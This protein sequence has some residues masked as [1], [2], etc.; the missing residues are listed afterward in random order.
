MPDPAHVFGYELRQG[1]VDIGPGGRK[2]YRVSNTENDTV[3]IYTDAEARRDFGA[4]TWLE[5]QMGVWPTVTVEP[6]MEPEGNVVVEV[7][8]T[9][10]EADRRIARALAALSGRAWWDAVAAVRTELGADFV[11]WLAKK[12][13]P[14]KPRAKAVEMLA[15]NDHNSDWALYKRTI[16]EKWKFPATPDDPEPSPV[17]AGDVANAVDRMLEGA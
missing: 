13:R 16:L 3:S 5:M 8:E 9:P 6:I 4:T 7:S 1:R 12:L 17:S 11:S 14:K 10:K 2:R 15:W